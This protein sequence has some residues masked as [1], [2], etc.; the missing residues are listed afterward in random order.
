MELS[1]LFT[2]F[3]SNQGVLGQERCETWLISHRGVKTKGIIKLGPGDVANEGK[4][5]CVWGNQVVVDSRTRA[6]Q[7][8]YFP[9]PTQIFPPLI[10]VG[11]S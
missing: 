2:T 8:I 5:F 10:G 6:W 1:L 4:E 7:T 3:V 9:S 11:S